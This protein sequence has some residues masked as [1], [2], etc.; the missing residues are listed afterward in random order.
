MP[1]IIRRVEISA[2]PADVWRTIADFGAVG[3][4]APHVTEAHCTTENGS[5]VGCS[6]SLTSSTGEV[7]EE[8]VTEWDEGRSLT[9]QVP[10]GLAR[11]VAFFQENWFVEAAPGGSAVVVQMEYRSRFGPVG[12]GVTRLV[13]RPVLAK[14][15]TENLAGL[16]HYVESGQIVTP[17]TNLP[18]SA[19]SY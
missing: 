2:L 15:L 4:W 7:I 10:G 14:M 12:A 19:V 16:K 6:R 17:E 8:V 3:N 11:V 5:G 13:V 1:K 18:V 9:F